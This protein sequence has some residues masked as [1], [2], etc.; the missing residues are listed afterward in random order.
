MEASNAYF[1]LLYVQAPNYKEALDWLQFAYTGDWEEA[2]VVPE[3][4]FLVRSV[5]SEGCPIFASTLIHLQRRYPRAY[6]PPL[7]NSTISLPRTDH[8]NNNPIFGGAEHR[9]SITAM[10]GG[11][12]YKLIPKIG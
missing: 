4:T 2:Y 10:E 9:E 8:V 1:L 11:W 6:P 7:P 5:V 3:F 12:V